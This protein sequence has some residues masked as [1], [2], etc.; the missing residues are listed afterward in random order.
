MAVHADLHTHTTAS[1]GDLTPSELVALAAARRLGAL[2]ITD[3]DTLKG[4]LE[5]VQA[6][7][8][9]G[10]MVIP[11]VEISAVFEPGTLHMLGY[12]GVHPA[13]LEADLDRVQQARSERF[14]KIIRRLNDLG[15]MI[16]LEEVA[17]IAGDAQI[18]RPHIAKALIARGYAKT[19]DE[20]FN[21]WLGKGKPAYVEKEK[22][23][24]EEA[25]ALIL[26]HG[27]VPVMAHPFTLELEDTDLKDFMAQHKERG[28]RG[29]EVYYPEH[30]HAQMRLYRDIARSLGL[31]ATG[32]TDFHGQNRISAHLG[33]TGVDKDH[34]KALMDLL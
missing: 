5:G 8:A 33:D 32:G 18:G 16:T 25:I 6:G 2:A 29:I 10:L 15:C 13:G 23:S 22:L 12:F 11:G 1:D 28:L 30:S 17:A 31:V 3:H 7:N 9:Q 21:R 14:P 24:C 20:A 26:K 19:F 4:V 34:L 27:G